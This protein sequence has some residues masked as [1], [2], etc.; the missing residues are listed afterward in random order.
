MS[1]MGF[2]N[3]WMRWIMFGISTASFSVL[4]NGSQCGFFGSSRG[5][6]HGDPLSTMLF[7]LLMKA[8]SKMM[9][10]MFSGDLLKGVLML[11]LE[12]HQCDSYTSFIYK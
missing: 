5:L 11:F 3:K 6:R 4:V 1:K 8:L 7:I 2:R 12:G 10:M 9:N